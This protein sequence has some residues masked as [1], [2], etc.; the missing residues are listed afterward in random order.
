MEMPLPDNTAAMMTGS[1]PFGAVG[2]GGMFSVL[3]VRKEQKP[4]DYSDPG[5]FKHPPGTRGLRMDRRARRPGALQGRRRQL[6]A[7]AGRPA[8]DV[9]VKVAQARRPRRPLIARP[10][11]PTQPTPSKAQPMK[12]LQDTA[13]GL[14]AGGARPGPGARRR[15]PQEGQGRAVRKEQKDWGIAGDAQAV[16]RTI[17]IRMSDKMRFTPDRIDVREGETI[18]LRAPQRRQDAARVRARHEGGTRGARRADAQVPEH[19][20]RRALHGPRAA[21]PAAARSSGPSTAPA[22][23][24]S[25]A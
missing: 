24:T 5:W 3:K 1:G 12:T 2:M 21:G 22:S 19:G 20:T 10:V 14:D 23:S 7:A 11:Q 18:R 17:E 25:P 8:Q 9:E 6:D 16:T 13:A 15:R 4:G